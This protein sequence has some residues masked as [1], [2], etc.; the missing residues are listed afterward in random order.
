[1]RNNLVY[2]AKLSSM[3][4]ARFQKIYRFAKSKPRLLSSSFPW[5]LISLLPPTTDIR[6]GFSFEKVKKGEK[7]R[8]LLESRIF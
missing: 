5:L 4:R 1:M 8:Q 3:E 6:G 2:T 7:T